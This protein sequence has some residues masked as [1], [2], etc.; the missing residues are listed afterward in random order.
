MPYV[1]SSAISRVEW[2]HGTLSIW[3]HE[4]GKYDYYGVPE[5]IFHEF[6]AAR[7]KG[8]FYNMYIKDRY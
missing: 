1:K 4:T 7:S 2:A 5:R 3:F 6:L 8:S